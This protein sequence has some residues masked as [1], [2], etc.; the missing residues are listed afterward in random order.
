MIFPFGKIERVFIAEYKINMQKGH[1]GLLAE[2]YKMGL[3]P[4]AGDLIIFPGTCYKR[5]KILFA[6]KNG[7]W[8][9]YKKFTDTRIKTKLR[10]LDK[11]SLKEVTQAE[12]S[13]LLEGIN[14]SIFSIPQSSWQLTKSK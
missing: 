5:I 4:W 7:L 6:D 13:L 12:L 8:V 1:D 10:F 2:A 14:F 11:Y 9:G 3:N